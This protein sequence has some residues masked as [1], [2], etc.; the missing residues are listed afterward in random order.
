MRSYL[1]NQR[2]VAQG[3]TVDAYLV[4]SRRK[5]PFHICK[6]MDASAHC[7]GDAQLG[8]HLAHHMGKSLPALMA[9]RDVEKH[10][11]VGPL[12]AV[13][14]AQG[15]RV[16]GLAKVHEIGAL[17]RLSVLDVKTGDDSFC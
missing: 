1:V 12:F 15:H 13:G 17:H 2:W 11:F 8:G 14:T 4:G 7:E 5:Q 9:G 3:R 10:Q 16:S 6:F